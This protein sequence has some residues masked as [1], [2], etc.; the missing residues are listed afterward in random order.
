M[1]DFEKY[2]AELAKLSHKTRK[3]AHIL[4]EKDF[5]SFLGFTEQ[6]I[7]GEADDFLK[8][9]KWLKEQ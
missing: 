9:E 8:Y 7:W 1:Q 5:G 3:A 6:E 2:A 4:K